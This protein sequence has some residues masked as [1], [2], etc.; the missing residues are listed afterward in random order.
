MNFKII[1]RILASVLLILAITFLLCMLCCFHGLS[2]DK[3]ITGL[4]KSIFLTLLASGAFYAASVGYK[5]HM[6]RRE[7][8][9]TIGL[10]WLIACIFGALP[11]LFVNDCTLADSFFEST[12]GLTSTGA[13]IFPHPENL[14]RCILLWR[15]VSQWIGGLGIVVFF[16]AL[17]PFSGPGTKLLYLNDAVSQVEEFEFGHIRDNVLFIIRIYITLTGLCSLM[18]KL[19]GMN[20]FDSLCHA[21][22]TIAT[23]GFSTHSESIGYFK[24]RSIEVVLTIFMILGGINFVL[25]TQFLSRKYEKIREN[26]ELKAYFLIILSSTVALTVIQPAKEGF[27]AIFDSLQKS[28]FTVSSILTSTGFLAHGYHIFLPAVQIILITIM[29]I[30]G[31]AGSTSGG[32][33]VSRVV[34]ASKG[35]FEH[36]EKIFRPRVVRQTYINGKIIHAEDQISVLN[37]FVTSFALLSIMVIIFGFLENQIS[38]EGIVSVIV[39][40]FF[41]TGIG[42]KELG[43]PAGYTTISNLSKFFLSAVMIVGR[44][45]IYAMLLLFIPSFWKRYG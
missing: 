31:C 12:S 34:M 14:P 40:N 15:A 7:A 44:V 42:F 11:Y 35:I 8:L 32:L 30:G 10:S 25:M 39:S 38:F 16:I 33:K 43:G 17:V 18:L 28:L 5:K 27:M 1:A 9:A 29:V 22:A 3:T 19:F 4:A 36:M 20:W 21:M 2:E 45:E 24:S 41:N 37:Y 13:T 23:G 6:F 26:T